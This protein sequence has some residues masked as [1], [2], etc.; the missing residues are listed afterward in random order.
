VRSL[1]AKPPAAV[2]PDHVLLAVEASLPDQGNAL[3][4]SGEG[5]GTVRFA[6][7]PADVAAVSRALSALGGTSFWVVLVAK[8]TRK[9]RSALATEV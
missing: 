7:N 5:D 8:P 1:H 3:T 6:I 9:R 4:Q 2:D